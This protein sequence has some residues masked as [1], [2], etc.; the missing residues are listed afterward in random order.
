VRAQISEGN[1]TC[2]HDVS[3]GG[4]AC[5]LAEMCLPQKIGCT[6]D[7]AGDHGFWFGE[8][9]GRYLVGIAPEAKGTFEKAA[10]DAGI[11]LAQI[12]VTG[13]MELTITGAIT[14]S[15][16]EIAKVHENWFP[17]LMGGR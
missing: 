4:L 15:L 17:N 3:D 13:G 8:D 1:A 12:G 10:I 7:I 16:E 5:A 9:Q 2:V 11:H 6:A 14:I